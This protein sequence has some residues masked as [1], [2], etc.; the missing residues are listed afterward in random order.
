M[1]FTINEKTQYI[2]PIINVENV[3][4]RDI[5]LNKAERDINVENGF[6]PQFGQDRKI[7]GAV[8]VSHGVPKLYYN[9][10]DRLIPDYTNNCVYLD[11]PDR[12]FNLEY[13]SRFIPRDFQDTRMDPKY[14]WNPWGPSR[15]SRQNYNY[16]CTKVHRRTQ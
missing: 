9:L 4:G 10:N 2:K 15:D 6:F 1:T 7:T 3:F 11:A 8:P 14:A 5:Q 16:N 12:V 13:Y